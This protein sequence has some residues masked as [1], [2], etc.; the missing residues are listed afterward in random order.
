MDLPTNE[1]RATVI[2]TKR[3]FT[4]LDMFGAAVLLVKLT[5]RFNDPLYGPDHGLLLELMLGQ[6]GLT[7]LWRLLRGKG[8]TTVAEVGRL[9]IRYDVRPT[10]RERK[11]GL[12]VMGVPVHEMGRHHLEGWGSGDEHLLRPDELVVREGAR[13]GIEAHDYVESMAVYGMVDIAR[14]VDVTPGV[15]EVYMSD[16]ELP[17]G[18]PA[19]ERGR[20]EALV[21]GGG[22]NVPFGEGE[23]TPRLVRRARR[24]ELAE[25]VRRAVEEDERDEMLRALVWEDESKT[26]S[27]SSGESEESEEAGSEAGSEGSVVHHFVP[28]QQRLNYVDA[29]QQPRLFDDDSVLGSD[30]D[31][32]DSV[33]IFDEEDDGVHSRACSSNMPDLQSRMTSFNSLPVM[34]P[35]PYS[36]GSP[37]IVGIHDQM[38]VDEMDLDNENMDSTL[39]CSS[40]TATPLKFPEQDSDEEEEEDSDDDEEEELTEEE[41]KR[42][43]TEFDDELKAQADQYYSESELEYDWDTWREEAHETIDAR[44]GGDDEAAEERG[45]GDYERMF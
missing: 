15:E 43:D 27:G 33:S 1:D 24:E 37:D 45:M 23:W 31:D 6:R 44:G 25:E 13:R 8:Y 18:L 32:G 42:L 40:L 16:E 21:N 17:E 20:R 10:T 4:D 22:G 11:K 30:S 3:Y 34:T 14:G 28:D 38:D 5:M 2:R 41:Q 39:L 29:N 12:P 7:P 36:D 35:P 9:K 19:E 26:L